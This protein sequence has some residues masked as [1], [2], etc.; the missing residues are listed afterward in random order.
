MRTEGISAHSSRAVT[1]KISSL[2]AMSGKELRRE[3]QCD[4]RITG[5]SDVGETQD[6]LLRYSDRSRDEERSENEI[7]YPWTSM[8]LAN[9]CCRRTA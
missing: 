5:C 2:S 9:M 1:L 4:E 3:I 8:P 6:W 7:D